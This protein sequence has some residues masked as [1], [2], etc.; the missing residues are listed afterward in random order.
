MIHLK[1]SEGV[2]LRTVDELVIHQIM[3]DGKVTE[4]VAHNAEK[5]LAAD[6]QKESVRVRP[7]SRRIRRRDTSKGHV[8]GDLFMAPTPIDRDDIDLDIIPWPASMIES[9]YIDESVISEQ[10]MFLNEITEI[11]LQSRKKRENK[12]PQPTERPITQHTYTAYPAPTT[13]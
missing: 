2:T 11:L 5:D 10:D 12:P 1:K 7:S 8:V 9:G 6:E 3:P 4:L 13:E